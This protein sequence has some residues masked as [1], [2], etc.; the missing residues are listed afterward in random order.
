MS[1][2]FF[3][4]LLAIVVGVSA[5]TGCTNLIDGAVDKIVE[6]GLDRITGDGLGVEVD[7]DGD[8][9]SI[10]TEEGSFHVGGN[11]SL[12]QGFPSSIVLPKT[13]KLSAVFETT[14]GWMLAIEGLTEADAALLGTQFEQAG[15]V[16]TEGTQS[17]TGAFE[18]TDYIVVI[19]WLGDAAPLTMIV[20]KR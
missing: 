13:G 20:A 17:G 19:N 7:R 9:V 5:L 10:K 12:P 2:K 11:A 3:G 1:K 4:A 16:R 6:G 18:S 14:E 8:G 15:W